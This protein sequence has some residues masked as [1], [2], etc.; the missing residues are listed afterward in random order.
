MI[1]AKSWKTLLIVIA[2][3]IAFTS[4]SAYPPPSR[5]IGGGLIS[6]SESHPGQSTELLSQA[7]EVVT[8]W[9]Q[10]AVDLTLQATP[11][12]APIQQVRLMAIVQLAVHDAVNGITREFETYLSPGA[13]SSNASAEA[14][15]IAA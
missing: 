9:N 8:E 11:A 7:G 1:S 6:P 10:H 15:A 13:A 2:I 14:A 3:G 5:G 4:V 12:L